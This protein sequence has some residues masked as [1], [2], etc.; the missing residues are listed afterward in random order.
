M[1]RGGGGR[2]GKVLKIVINNTSAITSADKIT[3]DVQKTSDD[4]PL[5]KPNFVFTTSCLKEYLQNS[6]SMERQK[7]SKTAQLHP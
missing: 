2:E 4:M 1:C 7:S 5:T 6:S 3:V